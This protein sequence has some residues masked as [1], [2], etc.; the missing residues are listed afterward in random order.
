MLGRQVRYVP[1]GQGSRSTRE[2]AD[3]LVLAELP[4]A[5]ALALE[6]FTHEESER[7][8]LTADLA[9]LERRG[10]EADRLAKIA[11]ELVTG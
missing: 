10:R 9:L 5:S 3:G 2:P 8:L 1:P 4:Q 11:D 7:A 6:M